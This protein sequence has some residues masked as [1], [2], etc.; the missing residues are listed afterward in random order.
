LYASAPPAYPTAVRATGVGAAVAIGRLGSVAGPLA[1]GQLLAAGAGTAGVLLATSPGVVI[2]ALTII[3]V[4][5]RAA[6][7]NLPRTG[8]TS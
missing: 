6:P 5:V 2:A 4:M 3:S 1:A 8:A 7:Q